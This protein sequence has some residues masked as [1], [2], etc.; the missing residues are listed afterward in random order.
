[1]AKILVD[2]DSTI[3]QLDTHILT[4]CNARHG[5]CYRPDEVAHWDW[6]AECE[7]AE[8]L[9]GAE[10]YGS[11]TWQATVPAN[12]G[13]IEGIK[14]MQA[15]G[16]EPVVVSDRAP[17]SGVLMRDWLIRYGLGDLPAILSHREHRPKAHV[18]VQHNMA[19]AIEDAPHH[20]IA[21]AHAGIP[22]YL[23]DKPYNRNVVHDLIVR[24]SGWPEI[25]DRFGDY[26][27]AVA[28]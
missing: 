6:L 2:F 9:W 17:A 18:A 4:T 24:V 28:A 25:S 21:I 20:A 13:A 22:V 7:H 12:P 14:A 8:W 16:L 1:M 19:A 23:L 10:C 27:R 11:P 15:H 26:F 3:T 5:T